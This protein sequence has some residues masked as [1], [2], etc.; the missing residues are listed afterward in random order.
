VTLDASRYISMLKTNGTRYLRWCLAKKVG[1]DR[2]L[3]DEQICRIIQLAGQ[4]GYRTLRRQTYS[5]FF[6]L[7]A[8]TGLRVSEAIHLR[9]EDITLDGLVIRSTKFRKNRHSWRAPKSRAL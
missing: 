8:C 6:A 7:L 1:P 5:T 9:Y 2:I 3:S 4:S